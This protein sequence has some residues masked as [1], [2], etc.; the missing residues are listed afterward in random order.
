MEN[1]PALF[2]IVEANVLLR[3]FDLMSAE[4]RRERKVAM[5]AIIKMVEHESRAR[6]D[7]GF[8]LAELLDAR[9]GAG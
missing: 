7:A 3:S 1:D 4:A 9:R 5:E 2:G 6:F 8:L